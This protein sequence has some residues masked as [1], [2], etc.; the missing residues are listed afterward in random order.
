MNMKPKSWIWKFA[1][2]F[3]HDNN[4]TIGKTI[5]HPKDRRPFGTT[6]DHEMIHIEQQKDV[7]V[8]LFVFL[9]LFCLPFLFNPWRWKWEEEAYRKG[10]KLSQQKI[11]KILRS[12][13][14]GWLLNG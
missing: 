10:H 14:Y 3:A 4:T 6:L 2:P 8:F 1:W 7:G 13:K 5:Y 12:V 11:R 9:Y